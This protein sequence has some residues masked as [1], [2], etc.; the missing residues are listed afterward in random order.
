MALKV[1][2]SA[3]P[4]AQKGPRMKIHKENLSQEASVI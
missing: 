3:A 1:E 2:Y 4:T